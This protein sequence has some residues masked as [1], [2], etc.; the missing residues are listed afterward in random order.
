[1]DVTE[2]PAGAARASLARHCPLHRWLSAGSSR[3]AFPHHSPGHAPKLAAVIDPGAAPLIDPG[4]LTDERDLAGMLAGLRPTRE[5]GAAQAMA[6]WHKEVL[7]GAAVSTAA[8]QHDFLCRSADTYF[9]AVGTCK[10]GTD[11]A[12]VTDL[13]LRVRGVD[14]LRVA[15]ASVTPSLPAGNTERDVR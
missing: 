9:H 11:M 7:P 14:G 8:R 1:M 15:D 10:S 3:R 4:F 5:I 6:E 12:A 2:V 13:Q